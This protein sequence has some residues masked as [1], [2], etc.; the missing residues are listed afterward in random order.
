[1]HHFFLS[2]S[3]RFSWCGM[4]GGTKPNSF[5][6]LPLKKK[7]WWCTSLQT[8]LKSPVLDWYRTLDSFCAHSKW[9]LDFCFIQTLE[10]TANLLQSSKILSANNMF[11]R[12]GKGQFNRMQCKLTE[13]GVVS[14]ITKP[15][16]QDTRSRHRQHIVNT[17]FDLYSNKR[18]QWSILPTYL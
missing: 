14:R 18:H 8:S 10:T 5:S 17:K 11:I 9:Q 2:G 3:R 4:W 12:L 15:Q 6:V 16:K 7:G 13:M 1:M